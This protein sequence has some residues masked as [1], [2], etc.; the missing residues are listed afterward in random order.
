MVLTLNPKE[1][2]EGNCNSSSA[3]IL[4][5]SGVSK[6]TIKQIKKQLPGISWGFEPEAK[7]WTSEEQQKAVERKP[8]DEDVINN[9]I[10]NRKLLTR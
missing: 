9:L 8:S 10:K 4:I 5:K 3:T 7:P 2:Y 6:E 1:E